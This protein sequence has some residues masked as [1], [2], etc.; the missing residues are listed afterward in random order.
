MLKL[1]YINDDA[2]SSTVYDLWC[3]SPK[4]PNFVFDLFDVWEKKLIYRAAIV[5]NFSTKGVFDRGENYF[6]GK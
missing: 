1:A 5:I 6:C 3:I 4:D 2:F